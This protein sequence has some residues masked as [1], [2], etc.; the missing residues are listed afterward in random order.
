M[1]FGRTVLRTDDPRSL[2][3]RDVARSLGGPRVEQAGIAS[4]RGS[5]PIQTTLKPSGRMA[6][7]RE[8]TRMEWALRR[9]EARQL[10]QFRTYEN[11]ASG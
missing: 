7:G 4:R 10:V 11:K 1:G 5:S 2:L 3:L 9:W 6:N 8:W